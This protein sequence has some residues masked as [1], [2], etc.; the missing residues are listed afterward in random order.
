M[1]PNNWEIW[2]VDMPFEEG[3][4]S[5]LRPGLVIEC[6]GVYYIVGKMTTH[7]PRNNFPYEYALQD[8]KGAGLSFPTT[9]RLSQRIR[10]SN[11]RFR[12]RLGVI[13]PIDMIV[14]RKMLLDIS[15]AESH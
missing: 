10:L 4:G 5:K 12:K 14:I 3:I 15:S 2:L 1:T 8:W 6:D 7:P 9:L 13:Q 11:S